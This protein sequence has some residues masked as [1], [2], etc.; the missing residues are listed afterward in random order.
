MIKEI[1]LKAN[2]I[3]YLL[4]ILIFM[5]SGCQD[6]NKNVIDGNDSNIKI[7]F[8]QSYYSIGDDVIITITV[9]N[10]GDQE[11]VDSL[12]VSVMGLYDAGEQVPVYENSWDI[13]IPPN[14]NTSRTIVLN[15]TEYRFNGNFSVD[16]HITDAYNSTFFK[17]N[18]GLEMDVS[19]PDIIQ[20]NESFSVILNVTNVDTVAIE[21]VNISAL[22]G[23]H[24][25]VFDSPINFEIPILNSGVTN[26]TEWLVT[27]TDD[28]SQTVGFIAGSE[29]GDYV[30]K[31]HGINIKNI[32]EK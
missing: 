3:F 17:V 16:A 2:M 10:T 8:D 1:I 22:F 27:I 9:V 23:R 13:T 14:L 31:D 20:K 19:I 6:I 18:S 29:R 26:T 12:S 5:L 21:N 28:E 7:S 15:Q 4:I 25:T 32:T 11:L 24:F 30:R